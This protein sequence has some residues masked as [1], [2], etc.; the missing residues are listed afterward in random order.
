MVHKTFWDAGWCKKFESCRHWGV[1]H[2]AWGRSREAG[3]H[4]FNYFFVYMCVCITLGILFFT[5]IKKKKSITL[6]VTLSN[7]TP[8]N[9]FLLD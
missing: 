9:H 7:I 6:Y 8:S 3:L 2:D 5:N 1:D 4:L